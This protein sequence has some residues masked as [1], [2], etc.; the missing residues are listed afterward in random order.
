MSDLPRTADQIRESV[1]EFEPLLVQVK[2]AIAAAEDDRS[3]NLAGMCE[4]IQERNR[5]TGIIAG[6]RE[7]A[8]DQDLAA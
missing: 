2:D 5:I 3:I 8:D 1:A 7:L 6:L 4:L